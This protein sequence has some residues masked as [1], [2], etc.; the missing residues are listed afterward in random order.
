MIYVK[1]DG[2]SDDTLAELNL[3]HGSMLF[4]RHSDDDCSW[5]FYDTRLRYFS[6]GYPRGHWP[7]LREQIVTTQA[8][9]PGSPVYYH[10]DGNW[11]GECAPW[12]EEDTA[13][14]DAEWADYE[15]AK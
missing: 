6:K 14:A 3:A 8:A 12:S 15:A 4:R 13:R 2:V 9:F 10:G 11:Y 5:I 7:T 1:G